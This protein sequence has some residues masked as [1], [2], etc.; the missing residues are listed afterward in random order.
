MIAKANQPFLAW[1]LVFL[2]P[3]TTVVT[4][5]PEFPHSDIDPASDLRTVIILAGYPCKSV[6]EYSQP[7]DSTYHVSCDAN[8]HYRVHVSEEEVVTVHKRSDPAAPASQDEL[9]HDELMKKHLLSVVNLAGHD[10]AAVS[11]YERHESNGHT[12]TCEDQ[13]VYRIH[14]TPEGRVA[15]DKHPINK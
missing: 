13:S 15:V 2:L 1:L 5:Q 10:C 4:A 11:S 14:V 6:V 8:R 7:I 3:T 12:V 9:S